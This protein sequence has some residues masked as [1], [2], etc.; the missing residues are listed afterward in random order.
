MQKQFMSPLQFITRNPNKED[1]VRVTTAT[2]PGEVQV[3][4]R[5]LASGHDDELKFKILANISKLHSLTA[6][7]L[8]KGFVSHTLKN[9]ANVKVDYARIH[10]FADTI[11]SEILKEMIS[12]N[13]IVP[14][15][16][17]QNPFALTLGKVRKINLS[18]KYKSFR[19]INKYYEKVLENIGESSKKQ[20]KEDYKYINHGI[21]REK[22]EAYLFYSN[23]FAL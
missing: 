23:Q 17:L 6:N 18:L 19:E 5:A 3:I 21:F 16:I 14:S 22:V 20:E 8:L 11:D 2:H 13:D 9:R 12:E 1:Y 7:V 15:D 10:L 4:Y